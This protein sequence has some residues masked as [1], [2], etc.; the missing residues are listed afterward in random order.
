MPVKLPNCFKCSNYFITHDPAQPYGCRAMGFKS[1]TNPA[2]VVYANS[3]II[4]QLYSPKESPK[5]GK[6]NNSRIA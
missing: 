2:Q 5:G 3:G 6:N 1:K 4:C